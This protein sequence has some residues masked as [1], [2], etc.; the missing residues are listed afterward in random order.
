MISADITVYDS[1]GT[2]PRIMAFERALLSQK[3]PTSN[4]ALFS[5]I[6]PTQTSQTDGRYL[7]LTSKDLLLEAETSIDA[8][9]QSLNAHTDNHANVSMKSAPITRTN[10]IESSPRFQ[11]YTAKLRGMIPAT[12]HTS[13]PTDNAWK[14]RTPTLLN[15]SEHEFP[16]L[17]ES[18]KKPHP[19]TTLTANNSTTTHTDTMTA[20][21]E[22]DI[23][24]LEQ[25]QQAVTDALTQQIDV[26]RQETAQMQR[27]LQDH[28]QE[29]I[30]AMST[31]E[32]RLEQRIQSAIT[33]LSVSVHTAV[34]SMHAQ[35]TRYDAR[36]SQ[37]LTSFQDQA[38]R[39]T[40]QMDRMFQTQPLDPLAHADHMHTTP[41]RSPDH[42]INRPCVHPPLHDDRPYIPTVWD[43]DHTDH[44]ADGSLQSYTSQASPPPTGPDASTDARN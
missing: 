1:D 8:A 37:F 12:I 6:K 20:L 5:S 16:P 32:L 23:E 10:R 19:N 35:S 11:S 24:A 13:H 36:L 22:L 18:Q 43:M 7:I 17:H 31:L 14:R 40:T 2:N 27:T 4:Q 34:E 26:I 30:A 38:D 33:S 44:L 9:L 21:T 39:M 25:K 42:P 29:S 3:S 28:F 15:L 41:P